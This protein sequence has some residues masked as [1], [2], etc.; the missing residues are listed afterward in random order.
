MKILPTVFVVDD[1]AVIRHSFQMY[2]N[3]V[4]IRVRTFSSADEFLAEY[5][6]AWTGLVIAD[7]RMTGMNGLE[8]VK[9]LCARDSSLTAVLMTGNADELPLKQALDAGAIGLL[10]KPFTVDSLRGVIQSH[11]SGLSQQ[12][13][14]QKSAAL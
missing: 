10:Q 5:N 8:L 13:P 12:P 14:S 4:Q 7:I 2:L 11:F 9:Q 3:I 6:E 1:E